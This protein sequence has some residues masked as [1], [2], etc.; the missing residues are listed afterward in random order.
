MALRAFIATR[1]VSHNLAFNDTRRGLSDQERARSVARPAA[2]VMPKWPLRR[3]G[4]AASS[5]A[6]LPSDSAASAASQRRCSSSQRPASQRPSS[7]ASQRP[8][9]RTGEELAKLVGPVTESREQHLRRHKNGMKS[10]PRCR[11]Y[12]RLDTWTRSYGHVKEAAS[13]GPRNLVW[14]AERPTHYGGTWALGCLCCARTS[15]MAS[16]GERLAAPIKKIA[17]AWEQRGHALRCDQGPCMPSTFAS[18]CK[19]M[20]TA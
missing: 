16:T 17:S 5:N 13:A 3:N 19:L 10:C 6:G 2:C 4:E 1:Q 7:A 14:L 20:H 8:A 12:S 15:V 11:Y 9:K 18:I